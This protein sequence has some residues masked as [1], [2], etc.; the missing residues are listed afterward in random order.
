[1]SPLA[2]AVFLDFPDAQEDSAKYR[3]DFPP[4]EEG[5]IFRGEKFLRLLIWTISLGER[6]L[7][8][9]TA[10]GSAGTLFDEASERD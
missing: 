6:F 8:T 2:T 1:M 3:K 10:H 7:N 4:G 5:W 9:L